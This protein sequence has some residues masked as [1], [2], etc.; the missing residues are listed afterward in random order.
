MLVYQIETLWP[1]K[2]KKKKIS[3]KDKNTISFWQ[4]QVKIY[5]ISLLDYIEIKFCFCFNNVR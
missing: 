5:Y 2:K 1:Q 4:N 3:I